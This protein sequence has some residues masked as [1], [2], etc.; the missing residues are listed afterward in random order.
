MLAGG[1]SYE[2][3][4]SLA[5]GRRI[6]EALNVQGYET[7]LCDVDQALI[8]R[9]VEDPPDAV[10]LAL[11]G[12]PG[13]DGPLRAVLELYGIPYVGSDPRG[14]R[15]SW[16]KAAAKGQLQAAG[17]RTPRWIT[18]A[19]DTFRDLGGEQLV[20]AVTASFGLPLVVKPVRGG[21]GLGLRVV[22]GADDVASALMNC[23]SYDSSALIEQHVEGI[24]IAVSVFDG[25][26]GPRALPCVEIEPLSGSYDYAARYSAG[27]SRWHVPARLPVDQLAALGALAVRVHETLQLRDLSR[28]DLIVDAQ[29]KPWVLEAEVSPGMT[30]TSL[31]PLAGQA[32]EHE[33]GDMLSLLVEKAI[34]RQ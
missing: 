16:D 8:P 24:D 28:V 20:E 32:A 12:A 3:D 2:R 18:L 10:V 29:K 23:F 13:E 14:A 21:S 31:F 9:L 7:A 6:M 15:L 33:L 19:P 5:S 26:Q 34:A 17:I 11:H 25:P 27:H 4:V 1:P 30:E 22:R